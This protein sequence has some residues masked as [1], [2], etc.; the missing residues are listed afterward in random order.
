MRM[1]RKPMHLNV[2]QKLLSSIV[3]K[4]CQEQLQIAADAVSTFKPLPHW[5]AFSVSMQ[6]GKPAFIQLSNQ[7]PASASLSCW[8]YEVLAKWIFCV[9]TNDI[10]SYLISLT[11]ENPMS[12]SDTHYRETLDRSLI[13]PTTAAEQRLSVSSWEKHPLFF[14]TF[15]PCADGCKGESE[16]ALLW[17]S[18]HDFF[19]SQAVLAGSIL[20]GLHAFTDFKNLKATSVY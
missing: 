2:K 5:H 14:F 1:C 19:S 20:N 18:S 9:T 16:T 3:T 4:K 8:W 13:K 15:L 17:S 10:V 11:R 7:F 12:N 6:S